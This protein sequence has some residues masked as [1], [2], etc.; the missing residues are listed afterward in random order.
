MDIQQLVVVIALGAGV[1]VV[2]VAYFLGRRE[3]QRAAWK[4]WAPG[5][6][7]AEAVSWTCPFTS[8][9]V[10]DEDTCVLWDSAASACYVTEVA[11]RFHATFTGLTLPS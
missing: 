3:G 8:D 6:A 2:W 5:R 9:A 4:S 11:A 1:L 10:C 7:K